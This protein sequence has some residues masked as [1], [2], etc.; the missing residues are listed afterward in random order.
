MVIVMHTHCRSIL[1]RRE[2]EQIIS[3][4]KSVEE[5]YHGRRF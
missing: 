5:V 4:L 2:K 1:F 3:K